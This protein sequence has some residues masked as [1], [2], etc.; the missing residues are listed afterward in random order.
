[1]QIIYIFSANAVENIFV[2]TEI[3]LPRQ[4]I[5]ILFERK[6]PFPHVLLAQHFISTLVCFL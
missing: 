4:N 3:S 6:T 2:L 5:H 1:M